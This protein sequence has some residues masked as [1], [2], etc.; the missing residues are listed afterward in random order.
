MSLMLTP[1]D[2]MLLKMK[3][4]DVRDFY[5]PHLKETQNALKYIIYF[6]FEVYTQIRNEPHSPGEGGRWTMYAYL[7]R[8]QE[9]GNAYLDVQVEKAF[10][11]ERNRYYHYLVKGNEMISRKYYE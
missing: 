3:I 4:R 8:Q 1:T 5:S 6:L 10:A 2:H 7:Y 9:I 11:I